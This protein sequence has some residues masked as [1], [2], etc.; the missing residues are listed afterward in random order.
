MLL[1]FRNI[2][3][4]DSIHRPGIKKQTKGNTNVSETGSV[5]VLKCGKK[6]I[7]LGPLERASPSH[8]TTDVTNHM[9]YINT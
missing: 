4:S 8:W 3:F 9:G 2:D 1:P 7:L 5:P 6:H